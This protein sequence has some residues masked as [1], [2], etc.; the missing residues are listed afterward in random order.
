MCL[1][2]ASEII[3]FHVCVMCI[4]VVPLVI[5][6]LSDR[7]VRVL[8]PPR[9]SCFHPLV[10][11]WNRQRS[12][13]YREEFGTE[14]KRRGGEVFGGGVGERTTIRRWRG[15]SSMAEHS[16]P[17]G[18]ATTLILQANPSSVPPMGAGKPS[19]PVNPCFCFSP[20]LFEQ[21]K[22]TNRLVSIWSTSTSVLIERTSCTN[23]YSIDGYKRTD[24]VLCLGIGV[25]VTK[26]R[27]REIV[28]CELM[29][30]Q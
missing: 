19:P 11:T 22:H 16:P 17:A 27:N 7:C 2:R 13:G 21:Q 10:Q 29:R 20:W 4:S 8:S 12:A 3:P 1:I 30:C 6:I 25:G 24:R 18:A 15:D 23:L 28:S 9:V 26:L 14:T 5:H